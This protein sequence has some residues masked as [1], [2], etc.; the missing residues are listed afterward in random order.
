MFLQEVDILTQI[1]S[2]LGIQQDPALNIIIVFI[3]AII[4]L[5]LLQNTLGLISE[6][7]FGGFKR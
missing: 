4:I 6:G 2:L 1:Y 7:L 3:S 5:I